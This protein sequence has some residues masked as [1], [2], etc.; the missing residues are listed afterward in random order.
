MVEIIQGREYNQQEDILNE[1]NE[2]MNNNEEG[3]IIK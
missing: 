1:F 3:I 2:A